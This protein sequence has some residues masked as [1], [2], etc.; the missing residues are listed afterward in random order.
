MEFIDIDA[1]VA[2]LQLEQ[3]DTSF[4]RALLIAELADAYPD[5]KLFR[6]CWGMLRHCS[7]SV[8]GKVTTIAVDSCH[9]CDGKPIK[10]W[11]YLVVGKAGERLY[12]DPPTFTVADQNQQG[13]G[14]IPRADWRLPLEA[15]G[16]APSVISKVELHL[17]GHPPIDYLGD[18]DEGQGQTGAGPAD[19]G[20]NALAP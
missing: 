2:R 12:S 19:A 20:S 1:E 15:A 6:D 4:D 5:L 14:E 3:D 7:A 16:I 10:V 17:K 11:P 8:N 9:R 13:F 18:D